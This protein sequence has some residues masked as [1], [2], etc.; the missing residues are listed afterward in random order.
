MIEHQVNKWNNVRI[1][2]DLN[3]KLPLF[4][5]DRSSITQVLINLLMNARDAMP[6]GGIITI[7]SDY[8]PKKDALILMIADTGVGIS[9]AHQDK[10]FMPFFTT[11]PIGKGTG[12]GLSIVH[13]IVESH[14]GEIKVESKKGEGSIFTLIFP[15]DEQ[16]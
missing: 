14:G 7:S 4:N 16:H 15:R 2:T 8:D 6:Q 11:K 1:I 5:L 3:K 13:G 12:L 10:I 9:D